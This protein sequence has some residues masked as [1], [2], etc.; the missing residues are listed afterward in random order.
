MAAFLKEHDTENAPL[1]AQATKRI[2]NAQFR[3]LLLDLSYIYI[4]IYI[5]IYYFI[6]DDLP[7]FQIH[8]K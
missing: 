5:Y 2:D 4:Y 7:S 6:E 3:N 1:S 8:N